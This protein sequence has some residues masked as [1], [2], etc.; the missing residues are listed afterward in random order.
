MNKHIKV[1]LIQ[2]SF[3]IKY[4][5]EIFLDLIPYTSDMKTTKTFLF[6]TIDMIIRYIAEMNEHDSPVSDEY[7]V[8]Y[9]KSINRLLKMDFVHRM[10]IGKCSNFKSMMKGL[11]Y[12]SYLLIANVFLKQQFD[13]VVE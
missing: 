2:F 7:I 5:K 10:N 12:M 3:V 4:K 6:A 8:V 9:Y 13:Q 1:S 11:I